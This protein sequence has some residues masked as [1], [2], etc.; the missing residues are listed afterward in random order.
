MWYELLVR[1]GDRF[2]YMGLY[3]KFGQPPGSRFNQYDYRPAWDYFREDDSDMEVKFDASLEGFQTGAYM[4]YVL[5][6][7]DSDLPLARPVISLPCLRAA[8]L[9]AQIQIW[10]AC[11]GG[12]CLKRD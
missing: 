12:S 4:H 9:C 1:S 5:D 2:G 10:L 7:A 11:I 6:T 3:T 8:R